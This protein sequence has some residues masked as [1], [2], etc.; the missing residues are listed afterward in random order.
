M[1]FNC[2]RIHSASS[3][4]SI[5]IFAGLYAPLTAA[6]GFILAVALRRSGRFR[7]FLWAIYT[8]PLAISG[9][10]M[11]IIW[12]FTF[13]TEYGLLN[14]L[15]SGRALAPEPLLDFIGVPD[16]SLVGRRRI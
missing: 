7:H 11:A 10:S 2:S 8:L 3:V 1:R 14:R 9:V 13:D 4:S 16:D 6:T 5:A 12:Q 15:L